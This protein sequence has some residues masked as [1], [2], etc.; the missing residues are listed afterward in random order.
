[1]KSAIVTGLVLS[2]C[3]CGFG[4]TQEQSAERSLSE[5]AGQLRHADYAAREEASAKLRAAGEAARPILDGLKASDDAEQRARA[6]ALLAEL[7]AKKPSRLPDHE[8]LKPS[9]EE[10]NVATPRVRVF[11]GSATAELEQLMKL[12][13]DPTGGLGGIIE[14]SPTGEV[15]IDDVTQLGKGLRHALEQGQGERTSTMTFRRQGV[16]AT[17]TQLKDGSIEAE[18]D[19]KKYEAP[20]LDV[21][22]KSHPQAM[23]QLKDLGFSGFSAGRI[24]DPL[25][26]IGGMRGLRPVLPGRELPVLPIPMPPAEQGRRLGVILEEVPD[27]LRAHLT[28]PPAAQLITEVLPG[29]VAHTAGIRPND[30]LLE[31]AGEP[32]RSV[33]AISQILRTTADQSD[34]EVKVVSGGKVRTVT[35]TWPSGR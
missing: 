4:Q 1:M 18:I 28:L 17:I 24:F 26:P 31:V 25:G 27:V 13:R 7:D 34:V 21:F 35:V 11:G 6:L 32:A 2:F 20:S 8:P 15:I 22:E 3:I 5:W 16:E 30:V 23:G 19:G 9:R 33:E 12:L 29:S 14:L 10:P